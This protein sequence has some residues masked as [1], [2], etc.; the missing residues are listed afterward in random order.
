M[1]RNRFKSEIEAE[2]K[3]AIRDALIAFSIAI[4]MAVGALIIMLYLPYMQ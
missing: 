3:A 4:L 1:T 2:E